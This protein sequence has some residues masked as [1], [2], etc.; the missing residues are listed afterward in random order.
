MRYFSFLFLLLLIGGLIYS[1]SINLD[2]PAVSSDHL[3]NLVN[4][5]IT[6]TNGTGRVYF[7]NPPYVGVSYQESF[8]NALVFVD[9]NYNLSDNYDFL[10]AFSDPS[11]S[12]VE[13]YSGGVATAVILKSLYENK[14]ID[15]S[16]IVTGEINSLGD[17]FPVGGVPE[18]LVASYFNNKSMLLIPSSIPLNEK[19]IAAK[20]S[21][22]FDFHVY[23]Y[24]DFLAVYDVYTE[25]NLDE[26]NNITL[27][28]ENFSNVFNLNEVEKNVF[29]NEIVSDMFHLYNKELIY[30]MHVYPDFMPYF[31]SIYDGSNELCGRGGYTYSAGNELFLALESASLLTS[32]Y[33]DEEFEIKLNE[34]NSCLEETEENLENYEGPL[35]YFIASE[36]RYVKAKD[37]ID[38]YINESDNPS[39]RF[40]APSILTRSDLWCRSA[41]E[42]SKNSEYYDYDKQKLIEFIELKLI[43]YSGNISSHLTDARKFYSEGY[44]GASLNEIITYEGKSY[45]CEKL[46]FNYDWSKMMYNHAL[47][48]NSSSR[49]GNNSYD[50]ISNFACAY[51]RN[52]KEYNALD[53][54]YE[55][56]VEVIYDQFYVLCVILILILFTL[57]ILYYV[58]KRGK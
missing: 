58:L 36:V 39:I 43:K 29:F 18:K 23:E 54:E 19:I 31:E 52:L 15:E 57:S 28:E 32:S 38:S 51:E 55:P 48:L 49:Y 27:S 46:E 53:F 35:E 3:G 9:S 33:N 1:S 37:T 2:L 47:Y 16:I 26:I 8:K 56:D 21:N 20:V 4:I 40:Y 17:I 22:E 50:E 6:L 12:S 41:L 5:N 25:N 34:I 42:M 24:D 44:Y 30:I 10:I 7:S 11:T 45:N 13:G 14:S